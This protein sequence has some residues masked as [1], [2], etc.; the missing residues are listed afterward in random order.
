MEEKGY[1][2]SFDYIINSISCKLLE[3]AYY[4]CAL[5]QNNKVYVVILEHLCQNNDAQILIKRYPELLLTIF[6]LIKL[7][8]MILIKMIIK[9]YALQIKNIS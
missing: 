6:L 2:V 8:F 7:F 3:S 1:K 5:E 9:Y 4:L